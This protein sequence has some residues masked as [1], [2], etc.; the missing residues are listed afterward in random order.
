MRDV[1][2]RRRPRTLCPRRTLARSARGTGYSRPG[3]SI[4]FAGYNAR[5]KG[6]RHAALAMRAIE[7]AHLI[8]CGPDARTVRRALRRDTSMR[9]HVLGSRDDMPALYRS[10]DVLLHPTYFDPC[11][12]V[13]LEAMACGTPCVTTRCNGASEVGGEGLVLLEEPDDVRSAEAG[14]RRL[15][16]A[17]GVAR[18]AARRAML[19]RDAREH[20]AEL[21][22]LLSRVAR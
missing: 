19:A 6:L 21:V 15:L 9:I 7:D 5:L 8:V 4:L 18:R 1:A 14:L 16:A 22:S 13:V 3:A 17:R 11:S 2:S 12:L 10:V 20:F